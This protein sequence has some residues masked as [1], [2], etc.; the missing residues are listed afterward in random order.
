[1]AEQDPAR[2]CLLASTRTDTPRSSSAWTTL[3]SS[4]RTQSKQSPPSQARRL[5]SAES[6]TKICRQGGWECMLTR[7]SGKYV[8]DE[9]MSATVVVLPQVSELLLTADV[10]H[11]DCMQAQGRAEHK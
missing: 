3:R 9:A 4:S 2:S 1:V 7:Y 10:P 5:L 11:R 6:T 8:T